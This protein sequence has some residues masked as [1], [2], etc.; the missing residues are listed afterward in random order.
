MVTSKR[1]ALFG[2]TFD[3]VHIGHTMV[4]SA[5]AEHIGADKVIFVPA[6]RSPLKDS[7]PGASDIDRFN[8][9]SLAIDDD[10]NFEVSDCELKRE[11]P[12]YTIDTIRHFRSELSGEVS[13]YW[14]IGADGIGELSRWYKVEELIDECSLSVMYRA[15]FEK[16][17]F[18]KFLPLWGRRRIEKLRENIIPTPLVDISSTQV[19]Q[20][21]A[22]GL[23]VAQVLNPQVLRYIQEKNLYR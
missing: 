1:I 15:G 13:I 18:E 16:P 17:D 20:R 6:R 14:L 11:Y 8:M 9:I 2:G 12:S 3:P 5:A 23:G 21:L 22:A 7:L 19:R 10:K 4:A